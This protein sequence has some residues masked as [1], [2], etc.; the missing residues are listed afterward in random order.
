MAFITSV[1]V[2]RIGDELAMS[3]NDDFNKP[4]PQLKPP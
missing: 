3:P 4:E 1:E 2:F